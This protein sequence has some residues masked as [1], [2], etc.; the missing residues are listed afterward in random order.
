MVLAQYATL[1]AKGVR[2]NFKYIFLGGYNR[3]DGVD[4]IPTMLPSLPGFPRGVRGSSEDKRMAK[5]E[6]Y[7][8][9]TADHN[10][11]IIDSDGKEWV[12]QSHE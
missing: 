5:F 3:A 7:K 8:R 9:I 6:N 12:Y 11:I 10:W 2:S 1:F 4:I